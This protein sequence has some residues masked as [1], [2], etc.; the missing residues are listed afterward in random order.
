MRPAV[1]LVIF[2]ALLA[3][4]VGADSPPSELSQRYAH[5]DRRLA[6]ARRYERVS[7]DVKEQ[8]WEWE[9]GE[10]VKVAREARESGRDTLTELSLN[11]DADLYFVFRQIRTLLP[12]GGTRV[13]EARTYFLGDE[14]Q[15]STRRSA[16]F[17]PGA[18]PLI[19]AKAPSTKVASSPS[20]EAE[21][22]A[23]RAEVERILKE[24]RQPANLVDDPARGA[25]AAWQRVKLIGGSLSPDGRYALAWAPAKPDFA[26]DEYYDPD[27][28]YWA[29]D[30]KVTNFV[31]DLRLHRVIGETKA[32]HFGSRQRYNH[33]ECITTWSPDSQMFV[34]LT[35]AKWN[36]V[37]CCVGRLND[38][39]LE[40]MLDL[41][42]PVVARAR[43]LLESG[44]RR[45]FRQNEGAFSISLGGPR[46]ANDGS[47]LIAVGFEVPKSPDAPSFNVEV[48]F[49]FEA[50][51][52]GGR[53][54]VDAVN[55]IDF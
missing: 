8:V 5:D 41:A 42:T 19:P 30:D 10:A 38:G 40:S 46:L 28:G 53:V 43:A 32:A 37:A 33:R 4:A 14:S 20:D 27:L 49:R 36:F 39:R 9:T 7:A 13:E 12:D 3:K 50:A 17:P 47:G 2:S 21:R 45:G 6:T 52:R 15:Q 25:N 23:L 54:R 26:W 11:S 24:V 31:V 22:N 44:K 34:Q 48:R 35:A 18:T 55:E 16:D 51:G 29:D 1:L